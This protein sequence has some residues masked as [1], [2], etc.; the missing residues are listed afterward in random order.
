M[1]VKLGAQVVKWVH[2]WVRKLHFFGW[3]PSSAAKQ[4][5]GGE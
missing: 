5:L 4:E 3:A 2:N 1:G